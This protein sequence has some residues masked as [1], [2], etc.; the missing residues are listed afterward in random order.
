MT[1][2]FPR[3]TEYYAFFTDFSTSFDVAL[4]DLEEYLVADGPFDGVIGF[5]QGA[6]L[7]ASLMMQ[8][9][10]KEPPQST[11]R[12]AIFICG[13]EPWNMTDG[14]TYNTTTDGELI[15][16]PVATIYGSKDYQWAEASLALSRLCNSQ[17]K[18]VFDH[19]RG[20][21]IPR[22]SELTAGMARVIRKVIDRALHIH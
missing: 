6:C 1:E 4:E 11:F 12:C 7:A 13:I 20:H 3:Q 5:S 18:E 8:H 9:A 21:E 14:R 22:T 10:R 16:V 2:I 17:T 19:G 15:Q